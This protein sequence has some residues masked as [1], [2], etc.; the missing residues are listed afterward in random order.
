MLS[1]RSFPPIL[2]CVLS[3]FK[4]TT[5]INKFTQTNKIIFYQLQLE[6]DYGTDTEKAIRGI[7]LTGEVEQ[8]DEL[9]L[10]AKLISPTGES[11]ER[12]IVLDEYEG[13]QQ[14]FS[15]GGNGDLWGFSTL[16]IVELEDWEVEFT[17][18]NVLSETEGN[19]LF[20]DI[21]LILYV[22]TVDTQRVKCSIDGEDISYYGA[23]LTDL[24]IPEGLETDTAF[25]SIDGTDTND[26]YRQNIREKTITAEFD[27]GNN[28]D[29][30][31]N[32]LSLREFTKLLVNDRDE[33]NRPIPKT[34]MF[35][36]Y[37]D[38][39]WEYVMEKPFDTELDIGT[40]HI[41]ASLTV[42][43]GTS[44]DRNTTTTSNNGYVNGI[45]T[46]NPTII[47]KPVSELITITEDLTGQE[48]HITYNGEWGNNILEIDCDNRICWMKTNEEDTEPVNMNK[49]VD[50]NSSWFRLKGEYSFT[51][52]GCIVRTVD[53]SERW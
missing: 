34:I 30:E 4:S 20:N 51:G 38:V 52:T 42:P 25:L 3:S 21:Q 35:S 49:Y 18:S 7:E 48:F 32:T 6:E 33:Y 10:Y 47:I 27:I 24:V 8:T 39:Y 44:Y 2:S 11:R 22:E 15:I 40:Y 1:V 41:K 16:D 5:K 12:S 9:V 29:I 43:A 19:L 45:A 26:A 14:T 37:P 31:A 23:F 28:C 13:N 53:Y 36:H 46:V 17:V 50:F